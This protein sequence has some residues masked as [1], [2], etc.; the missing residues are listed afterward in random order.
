MT[1]KKPSDKLKKRGR[2]SLF[3][4]NKHPQQVKELAEQGKTNEQIADALNISV[5]SLKLWMKDKPEFSTT[6][7]E[8][9]KH[10]DEQVVVS[11]YK[12][13]CGYKIT[14]KKVIKNPDGTTRMELTEKEIAPDPTSM[15]FW[16][17]N[18]QPKDWR[19]KHDIEQTGNLILHF[20]K[21]DANL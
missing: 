18:R 2:K 21:E 15:I 11:L 5:S 20:D 16:L 7:K 10:S 12:R 14:E 4:P 17:K 1:K 6:I 8:G 9:K 19:D 3:D 13:A